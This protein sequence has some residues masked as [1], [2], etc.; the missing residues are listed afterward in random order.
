MKNNGGIFVDNLHKNRA[1]EKPVALSSTPCRLLERQKIFVN[2]R[3]VLVS[4]N[5]PVITPSRIR[6]LSQ[7]GYDITCAT[8]IEEAVRLANQNSF[9]LLIMSIEEPE[10]LGM[11]L[12]QF[13]PT[14]SIMLIAS[15]DIASRIAEGSG[16][17][18]HSFL[19]KPFNA[20]QF[21]RRASLTIDKAHQV[22]ES[23][24]SEILASLE[25][26]NQA[27]SSEIGTDSFFSLILETICT[28][29]IADYAS[30]TE[31]G[32]IS[33]K[34][35]IVAQFG[36]CRPTW[37]DILEQLTK[38]D[39]PLILN[40]DKEDQP[41]LSELLSRSGISSGL[42]VPVLLKGKI[43][44][45]INIFR[46]ED[47]EHFTS[48]DLSFA[49]ILGWWA[50]L[51]VENARLYSDFLR[52]N[53]YVDKLLDKISFVQEN[54]RKRVAIDIHDGVAQWLVGATYD[55]KMCSRLISESKYSDLEPTLEDVKQILQRSVKELRRTIANLPLPPLEEVGLIGTIYRAAE[56]LSKEGIK[57]S[58]K[59]PR[60]MPVLTLAQTKT[61]YWIIQESLTNIRKHS[62]ASK[63][64]IKIQYHDNKISL[65]ISDNG[66]GFNP[67]QIMNSPIP[68][69]HM[70]LMGM[71]ERAELLD[72]VIN[73]DSKQ[74]EGTTVF[75]SFTLSAK[76]PRKRG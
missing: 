51:V 60:G 61:F 71:R 57:C 73:I 20:R 44:G 50:S 56:I 43:Y 52:E 30:I 33:G 32:E 21:T 59:V 13:P 72:G 4:E 64:G 11:L 36:E 76:T 18:I 24:R 67:E 31:I 25:Q 14:I 34:P 5:D 40:K 29:T 70:G 68:L 22:K 42:Y 6:A 47:R 16:A 27:F 9:D 53:L 45:A 65:L 66:T 54:E 23:L 55:V 7:G 3:K 49:K 37:N 28:E 35:V 8:N 19:I 46:T 39:K 1:V 74:G 15:R 17:G 63:V 26:A 75:L 62:N 2:S 38:V 48:C 41:P 10:L 58:I 69:E 12:A